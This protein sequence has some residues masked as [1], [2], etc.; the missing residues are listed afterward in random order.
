MTCPA[1]LHLLPFSPLLILLLIRKKWKDRLLNYPPT[2]LNK[3]IKVFLFLVAMFYFW[4]NLYFYRIIKSA[5]YQKNLKNWASIN[6]YE[7]FLERTTLKCPK[8]FE[9]PFICHENKIF[10]ANYKDLHQSPISLAESPI[11]RRNPSISKQ[12]F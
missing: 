2:R 10:S 3:E 1:P 6:D 4:E 11:P 7:F 8:K 5:T 9:F 12:K